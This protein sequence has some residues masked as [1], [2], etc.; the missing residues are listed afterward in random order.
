MQIKKIITTFPLAFIV[1]FAMASCNIYGSIIQVNGKYTD[2][3]HAP[4][5]SLEKHFEIGSKLVE[6][7]KW[8][9]A[10]SNFLVITLHFPES[11]LSADSLFF[12]GICYYYLDD[13]QMANRQ[14]SLYLNQK[15]Q[16][17]YFDKVFLYKYHIAEAFRLGAKKHLFNFQQFP[18]ILSGKAEAIEIYDEVISSLPYQELGALSLYGKA[19]LLRTQRKYRES[20]ESLTT[21]I[22]R[23]P[24][25]PKTPEAYFFISE[26]YVDESLTDTQ[27][28]D[29]LALAKVNLNHFKRDFPG[30]TVLKKVEK[31]LARMEEIF[32]KSLYE[33][34]R[35]YEKKKKHKASFIYYE[36]AVKHYPDTA[37][38]EKSRERLDLLKNRV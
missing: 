19:E 16:L 37:S 13:H 25:H 20:I 15:S 31:N 12:S 5:F 27:N 36:E 35:F 32:A 26:I 8:K 14:L 38:A 11:L 3:K 2:D 7:N 1:Y 33:T 4:I 24:K 10:L 22:K 21:L 34:G 18:K 9:E 29:L 17:K 23:F 6:E 28:P 30:E